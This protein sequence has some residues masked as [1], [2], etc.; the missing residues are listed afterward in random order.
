MFAGIPDAWQLVRSALKCGRFSNAAIAVASRSEF[1]LRTSLDSRP[2]VLGRGR[3]FTLIELILVMALLTISVSVTAPVLSHFFRG[4]T[5]DSEA[6]RLLS[7]TRSG[8]SRAANEGIPMDLWVNVEQREYGLAAEPSYEPSDPKELIC[9]LDPGLRI[10]VAKQGRTVTLATPSRTSQAATI[11]AHK[12]TR[13]HVGLPAIRFLPD[14]TISAGSPQ[15][16]RLI[17]REESSL[18]VSQSRDRL[19]YEIRDHED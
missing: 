5:L 16:L 15:S 8:A 14:G 1:A 3:A 9:S 11:S 2:P 6:R 19:G 13:A 7:L 17:G 18:W 4:R 12:V 10:E